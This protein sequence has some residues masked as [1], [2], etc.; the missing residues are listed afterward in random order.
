[1]HGMMKR[2]KNRVDSITIVGEKI[3]GLFVVHGFDDYV[4]LFIHTPSR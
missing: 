4:G 2:S 3:L 1:M